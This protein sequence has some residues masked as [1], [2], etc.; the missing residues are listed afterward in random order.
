[1]QCW[2]T[3]ARVQRSGGARRERMESRSSSGRASSPLALASLWEYRQEEPLL[4]PSGVDQY[5]QGEGL[6]GKS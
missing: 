5:L 1:M 2:L 3:V 4:Q 6:T